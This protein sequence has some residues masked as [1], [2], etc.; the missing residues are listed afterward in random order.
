MIQF[1]VQLFVC[2]FLIE[3]G[4]SILPFFFFTFSFDNFQFLGY[5]WFDPISSYNNLEVTPDCLL[6]P[7]KRNRLL[8]TQD[9][10]K[11]LFFPF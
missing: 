3:L 6:S 9:P 1:I 8:C 7:T 4:I 2:L 5:L 11:L 10:R